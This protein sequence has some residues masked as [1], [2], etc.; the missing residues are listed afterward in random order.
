MSAHLS[1]LWR[2][3]CGCCAGPRGKINPLV[4]SLGALEDSHTLAFLR[5]SY[6]ANVHVLIP[7]TPAESNYSSGNNT[8]YVHRIVVFLSL[9]PSFHFPL[10]VSEI[11]PGHLQS[12]Q[13]AVDE[14]LHLSQG[15]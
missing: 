6:S 7:C 3:D 11:C 15:R 1:A 12:L 2:G 10:L 5:M 14:L 4:M 13:V 8:L 9:L